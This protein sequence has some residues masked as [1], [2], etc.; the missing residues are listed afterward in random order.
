MN[1]GQLLAH[2]AAAHPDRP[3]ISWRGSTVDYATFDRLAQSFARWLESVGAAPNGRVVLFL[4]NRPDLLVAM[5][6]TFRGRLGGAA[7]QRPADRRASWRFLVEDGDASG[8]HHRRG[9][10][11]RRPPRRW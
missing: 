4:D 3:A 7:G 2:T 8:G 10:R 1:V 11:R 5:F 9:P 6:G